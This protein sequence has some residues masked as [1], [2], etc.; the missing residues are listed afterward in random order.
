MS[1]VCKTKTGFFV[2]P[3]NKERLRCHV[4]QPPFF[5]L[6]AMKSVALQ[7]RR[8]ELQSFTIHI[9]VKAAPSSLLPHIKT[10]L[11]FEKLYR[12]FSAD[13]LLQGLSEKS[14]RELGGEGP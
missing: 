10:F 2:Q 4:P 6:F 8:M 5:S 9:L 3:E 11:L 1:D 14:L 12:L 13:I 7:T